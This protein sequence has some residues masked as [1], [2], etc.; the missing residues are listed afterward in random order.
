M[1]QAGRGAGDR[2]RAGLEAEEVAAGV[3]GRTRSQAGAQ[4][5]APVRKG[6]GWEGTVLYFP[7]I[8]NRGNVS[9][10]RSG[11]VNRIPEQGRAPRAHAGPQLR[12]LR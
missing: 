12:V 1:A 7:Q 11:A 10:V 6:T 5:Q 8:S 9:W 2:D 3:G 4:D